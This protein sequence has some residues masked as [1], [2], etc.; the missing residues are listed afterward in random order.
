MEI[1]GY[2]EKDT[3]KDKDGFNSIETLQNYTVKYGYRPALE[4]RDDVIQPICAGVILTQDHQVLIVNKSKASTGKNSPEK[5][6]TLLYIGGHLDVSDDAQSNLQTFVQG[7]K[8][9]LLEE[10][11]LEI[12]DSNI[13]KPILT[14]TPIS[15]KSARHLGIIFPVIIPKAFDTNFTDGK[16]KFVDIDSLKLINNFESWSEIILQEIIHKL[17]LKELQL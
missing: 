3:F 12:K 16:C 14:Y 4:E 11:G 13:F 6:K 1:I 7:M 15:E 5:N 10:T 2:I 8:R 9:E 17:D